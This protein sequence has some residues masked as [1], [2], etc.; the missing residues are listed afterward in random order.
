MSKVHWVNIY[1]TIFMCIFLVSCSSD[2][3]IE[4]AGALRDL[5]KEDVYKIDDL[6]L[7]GFINSADFPQCR[8]CALLE[9]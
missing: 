1:V 7:S 6:V 5:L 2:Y 4:K 8:K 3:H 9:Y